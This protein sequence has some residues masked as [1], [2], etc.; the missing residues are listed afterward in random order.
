MYCGAESV[1]P[2]SLPLQKYVEVQQ[3]SLITVKMLTQIY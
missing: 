2:S 3:F 1:D